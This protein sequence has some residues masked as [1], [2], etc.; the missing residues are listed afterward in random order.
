MEIAKQELIVHAREAASR[1]LTEL[2]GECSSRPFLHS[3]GFPA[4]LF[5]IAYAS[6]PLSPRPTD[7]RTDGCGHQEARAISAAEGTVSK[8]SGGG[9]SGFWVVLTPGIFDLVNEAVCVV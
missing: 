8:G 7:V 6:H 2:S 4:G 5:T 3:A 9:W 1:I